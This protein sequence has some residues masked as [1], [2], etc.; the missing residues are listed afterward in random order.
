MA[1]PGRKSQKQIAEKYKGN[2]DYYNRPSFLR[3][4]RGRLFWIGLLVGV[5]GWVGFEKFSKRVDYYNPGPVSQSH[6]GFAGDCAKCHQPVDKDW[7]MFTSVLVRQVNT[8]AHTFARVNKVDAGCLDCHKGMD[9]HQPDIVHGQSCADCHTEH[10]TAGKMLPVLSANCVNCHNNPQEMA[11]ATEKGKTIPAHWFRSVAHPEI[12][13]FPQ[14]RPPEGYTKVFAHF[15]DSHPDF[16]YQTTGQSDP[17]TLKYNHQRHFAADIPAVN[18]KKLEC[19]SCHQPDATGTGFRRMTFESNCQVC[20]SLQFDPE[21]KE[22]Q[23]PHGNPAEVR[24]FLRSLPYQYA[25]VAREKLHLQSESDINRFVAERVNHLRATRGTGEALEN[26]VFFGHESKAGTQ[27]P[28][29]S[30][31]YCHEVTPTKTGPVVTAPTTPDRWLA[32][33]AF[34]HAPHQQMNCAQCHN[35]ANS[36][37]TADINLPSKASCVQCHSPKGGVVAECSTCHHYHNT[38]PPEVTATT[39]Q[40]ATVEKGLRGWL[41]TSTRR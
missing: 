21:V 41:M 1:N 4:W 33:A 27:S 28:F 31:N 38:L 23:V 12:R 8:P 34:K 35:V 39:A 17:N 37:S 15:W 20:H 29:A 18:G 32:N 9:V 25:T 16:R 14:P 22:L 19:S 30:C 36:R 26:A 6:A 40:N 24:A 13:K 3:S 10:R 2:L 5:L 7:P 11:A